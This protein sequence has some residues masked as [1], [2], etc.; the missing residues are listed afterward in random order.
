MLFILTVLLWGRLAYLQWVSH[1]RYKTLS[2]KNR[3]ELSPIIPNRGLILDRNQVILAE[4]KT[5]LNLEMIPEQIQDLEKTIGTL[6]K[7]LPIQPQDIAKFHQLKKLKRPFESIPIYTRLSELDL[8]RFS[9]NKHFFPGVDIVAH[10][11][12]TYPFGKAFAHTVGMVKTTPLYRSTWYVGETGIEKYYDSVL[13]GKTGFQAVETDANGKSIRILNKTA[14]IAGRSIQLT[15][16]SRLQTIAETAFQ[17]K[18]GAAVALNPKTGEILVLMS[19]PSFDPNW[20][21]QGMDRDT[22]QTLQNAPG[23]PLFDRALK[24]RYPPG[25]TIKPFLALLGLQTGVITPD[26]TISDPGYYQLPRQAHRY[27]EW[28]LE[29][30]GFVNLEKAIVESCDVYFYQLAQKLGIDAMYTFLSQF[31]FGRITGIDTAGEQTGLLPSRAWKRKTFGKNWY[32]GETLITGIGQGY[33]LST[34]IQL[35]ASTAQLANRG[36]PIVPRL[37]RDEKGRLER[38]LQSEHWNS[39]I[40]AM[41]DVVHTPAGTAWSIGQYTS[42]DIAG[43]TG[44]SQVFTVGQHEKYHDR[45]VSDTLRDHALF[46]GFTPIENPK[47]ALA[48]VVEN[49]GS[50]AALPIAKA[51]LE[52][53]F[54]E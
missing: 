48:V 26:V 34:P 39:V 35:A 32:P 23:H 15:L 45:L 5:I 17:N 6:Q 28:K 8:A 24:G 29:G 44:T 36:K 20:F 1:E 10:L 40:Q 13:R 38:V 9:E 4:S 7:I 47:I 2:E 43:K 25:S 49:G 42:L 41:K 53:F 22:Y 30:H 54:Y 16:D 37:K 3:I 31:G 18:K 50:G 12:R 46:I 11:I 14:P 51:I 52:G 27:R 33:L 21:V 19:S